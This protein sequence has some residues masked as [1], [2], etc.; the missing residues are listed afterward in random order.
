MNKIPRSLIIFRTKDFAKV[1]IVNLSLLNI[2]PGFF[3]SYS[4]LKF[5]IIFGIYVSL[6]RLLYGLVHEM[7]FF[8]WSIHN[9]YL[10]INNGIF[11]KREFKLSY[12]KILGTNVTQ[13][14]FYRLLKMN[15]VTIYLPSTGDRSM[16]CI[17]VMNNSQ[18]SQFK[19]WSSKNKKDEPTI[20]NHNNK[21]QLNPVS[22]KKMFISSFFTFN[23][24]FILTIFFSASDVF[25]YIGIDLTDLLQNFHKNESNKFIF[26]LVVFVFTI[27]ATITKQYINYSYFSII[28]S[29]NEVETKNGILNIESIK[30]YKG[31]I[32]GFMFSQTIGQFLLKLNSVKAIIPSVDKNERKIKNEDVLPFQSIDETKEHFKTLFPKWSLDYPFSNKGFSKIQLCFFIW[33]IICFIYFA[34]SSFEGFE[35]AIIYFISYKI[36]MLSCQ[37][38]NISNGLIYIEHGIFKRTVIVMKVEHIE[39][40]QKTSFPYGITFSKIALRMK[41][42]KKFK[43]I[44]KGN[45]NYVNSLLG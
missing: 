19:E 21:N 28:D 22:K 43:F 6:V 4:L 37:K 9:D 41:T 8:S 17:P 12:K 23:Y 13:P 44:G 15:K 38:L 39:W 18:L 7:F 25:K 27:I 5:F 3:E 2:F 16:L 10:I 34:L 29:E 14:F 42:L 31:D 26:G 36:M 1:A 32:S 33:T 20:I 35:I 30:I 40:A 11:T 24:L 45:A